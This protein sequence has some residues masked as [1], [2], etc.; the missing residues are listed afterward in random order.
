MN[1]RNIII[2]III[3]IIYYFI[4]LDRNTNTSRYKIDG[5]EIGLIV[6]IY[7]ET[8]QFIQI[9]PPIANDIDD[10]LEVFNSYAHSDYL[11]ADKAFTTS[12]GRDNV[13]TTTIRN[14]S[15]ESQFYSAFRT[16]LRILLNDNSNTEARTKLIELINDMRFM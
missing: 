14:I 15:L 11:E 5:D 9:D 3:I 2:S 7:T 6:G 8:N 1:I 12:S 4:Y 10:D 13:R 16:T